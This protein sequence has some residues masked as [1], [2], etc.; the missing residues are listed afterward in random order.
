MA[1]A[2]DYAQWIVSNADKKGTPEFDTVVSA[3]RDARSNSDDSVKP[4]DVNSSLASA[5]NVGQ[6]LTFGFGDE[7]AGKLG[8]DPARYRKTVD[9][10]SKEYPA[11]SMLGTISGSMAVPGAGAKLLKAY[12]PWAVAGATGGLYGGLQGA[13]DAEEGKALEGATKSGALGMLAAPVLMGTVGAGGSVLNAI[14]GQ[15]A[16]RVPGAGN[17]YSEWLARNRVAGALNRDNVTVDEL[18]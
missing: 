15:M 11:A 4:Y 5:M 13:G 1:T 18:S 2:D 6:A 16:S 7:I 3:Y 12:N 8:L 17:K 9:T 10:F 14:G